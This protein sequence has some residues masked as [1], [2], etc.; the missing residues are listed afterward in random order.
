MSKDE[1]DE[2]KKQSTTFEERN[3]AALHAIEQ[4][5]DKLNDSTSRIARWT[6]YCAAA[7]VFYLA[8]QAWRWYTST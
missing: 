2:W 7:A 5:L 3:L 4:K 6:E 8:I 1:Y